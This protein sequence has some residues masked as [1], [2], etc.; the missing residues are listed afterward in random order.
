MGHTLR[1]AI[2]AWLA[3]IALQTIVTSGS[4]RVS[5][6]LT[7]LNTLVQRALSPDVPAI[8]DRRSGAAAANTGYFNMS[9]EQVAAAVQGA[10]A[11][12]AVQAAGPDALWN[13]LSQVPTGAYES[14]GS[15]DWAAVAK[16]A[17]SMNH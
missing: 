7:G 14:L 2:T 4:G 13:Q 6:A 10:N 9:P 1:G 15:V 12:I 3:L 17:N 11:G 5:S 16:A 8:P